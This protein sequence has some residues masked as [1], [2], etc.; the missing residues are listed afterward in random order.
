MT[1]GERAEQVPALEIDGLAKAFHGRWVV[2][3]LSLTVERGSLFGLVGP[4]GAG[5]SLIHI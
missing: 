3:G 2:R 1:E 4:N 5:L